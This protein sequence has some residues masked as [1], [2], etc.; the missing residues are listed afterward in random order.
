MSK[1]TKYDSLAVILKSDLGIVFSAFCM[2]DVICLL[3]STKLVVVAERN[4]AVST[5]SIPVGIELRT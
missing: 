5:V 1:G 2:R 4:K 3:A